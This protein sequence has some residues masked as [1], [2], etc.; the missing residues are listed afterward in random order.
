MLCPVT[1]DLLLQPHLTACCG[2]HLSKEAALRIKEEQ[3]ACPL[4]KEEKLVT[5][6]DKNTSVK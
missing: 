4:C 1:T 3:G 6:L 2:K 5:I